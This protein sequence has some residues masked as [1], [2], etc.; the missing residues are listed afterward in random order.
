VPH[1]PH[2]NPL[3]STAIWPPPTTLKKANGIVLD[4]PGKAAYD[5]PASFRVIASRL[6]LLA[7]H[8]GLLHPHQM[9]SLR[10]TPLSMPHPPS[11]TRFVS[12]R[13]LV[14]RFHFFFWTLRA[15]SIMSIPASSHRRYGRKGPTNI[16]PHGSAVFLLTACAD[17]SSKVPQGCSRR[18][19][20]VPPRAP[21]S[22]LLFVIYVSPLHPVIPKGIVISYMDD[23]VVMVSS[24]SHRRNIQLLQSHFR[25]LCSIAAPRGL[26]FSVPKTELIHWRTPQERS[27]P[28]TAD[29]RLD[30]VYSS[31]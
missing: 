17:Y 2:Q 11:P 14:P 10:V 28:S 7:T 6:S 29:V 30:D 24:S 15:A 19:R 20:W 22:P 12:F 4:K 27:P 13:G 23:F 3:S 25:S 21:P 18:S 9:G 31:P 1:P 26:T 16:S 8:V 5:T